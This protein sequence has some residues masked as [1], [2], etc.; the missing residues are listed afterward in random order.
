[1]EDFAFEL[2]D[3]NDYHLDEDDHPGG[4]LDGFQ[5]NGG[6]QSTMAGGASIAG[7][8]SSTKPGNMVDVQDAGTHL[9][10]P[11]AEPGDDT[12]FAMA[13]ASNWMRLATPG[14]RGSSPET[15]MSVYSER[16]NDAAAENTPNGFTVAARGAVDVE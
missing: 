11:F 9:A 14:T 13:S 2:D 1:M 12:N 8:S 5:L 3:I 16:W 4:A 7:P 15:S 6:R 10:D